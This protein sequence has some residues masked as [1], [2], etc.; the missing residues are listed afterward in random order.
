MT[1]R[2]SRGGQGL[3]EAGDVA[4]ALVCVSKIAVAAHGSLQGLDG[5]QLEVLSIHRNVRSQRLEVKVTY[6][7]L[8]KEEHIIYVEIREPSV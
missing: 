7:H 4:K 3:E 8:G 6:V 5:I 2:L 1:L